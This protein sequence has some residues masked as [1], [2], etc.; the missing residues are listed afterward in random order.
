[1]QGFRVGSHQQAGHQRDQSRFECTNHHLN[2]IRREADICI[3]PT[4]KLNQKLASTGSTGG[5]AT[6][7]DVVID[8]GVDE[9]FELDKYFE[10]S[11]VIY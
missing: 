6:A 7:S 9:L 8:A 11:Q 2:Y 10:Q 3:Y 5:G 1:M 4:H